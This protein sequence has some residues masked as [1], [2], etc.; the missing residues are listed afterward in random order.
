MSNT[1]VIAGASRGIGLMLAKRYA[2]LDY[3]V[4]AGCRNVKSGLICKLMEEHK[5]VIAVSIDVTN[6]A[7][8]MRS[9]DLVARHTNGLDLLI[10]NAG[11]HGSFDIFESYDLESMMEIYNTNTVG[12]LRVSKAFLPLL[13]ANSGTIVNISSEA[14]SIAS[15]YQYDEI[16]YRCSK[17]ALNMGTKLLRNMLEPEGMLAFSVHPGWVRTDMGG[18]LSP[19]DPYDVATD[20]QKTLDKFISEKNPAIYLDRFGNELPW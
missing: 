11:I 5:N 10:N 19:N 16:G 7:E 8:V 18:D 3:T 15:T 17:A 14:G 12:Y 6:A 20:I 2:E 13:R 4:F 9:A 1:I